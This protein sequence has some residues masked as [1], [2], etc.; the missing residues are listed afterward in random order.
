VIQGHASQS[1]WAPGPGTEALWGRI[2]EDEYEYEH[3]Q[4]NHHEDGYRHGQQEPFV[5]SY[6]QH[7]PAENP[8]STADHA[9]HTSENSW[10]QHSE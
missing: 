2:P 10:N 4:H 1:N 9:A 6:Q 7:Q 3:H 8:E 5:D